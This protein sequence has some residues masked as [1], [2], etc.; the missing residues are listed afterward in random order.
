MGASRS[1]RSCQWPRES[2]VPRVKGGL[3]YQEPAR[4]LMSQESLGSLE[5]AG[6][7]ERV[8]SVSESAGC[9]P[10]LQESD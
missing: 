5:L 1:D 2:T 4:S 9:H 8:A 7:G 3:G 10:G 6:T